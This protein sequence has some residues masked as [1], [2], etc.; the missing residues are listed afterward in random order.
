MPLGTVCCLGIISLNQLLP[1]LSFVKDMEDSNTVRFDFVNRQVAISSGSF[2]NSY[3][4]IFGASSDGASFQVVFA[5]T[6]KVL[7]EKG[8][9]AFSASEAKGAFIPV[10]N[11]VEFF[12][13]VV[14]VDDR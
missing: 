8:N 5:Q 6:V 2:P 12:Y 13:C 3:E 10:G 4:P 9:V 1:I 14:G 7:N 11:F